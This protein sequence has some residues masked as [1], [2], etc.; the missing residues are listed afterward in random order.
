[1]N[2]VQKFV[3]QNIYCGPSLDR[4][5]SFNLV[6]VTKPNY[7]AAKTV[8]VYNINK[9]LPNRNNKFHVFAIGNLH[10][11]L[12]NLLSQEKN[13]FKDTWIK[14]SED[15][16][17][18]NYILK[19]YN[20]DGVIYPR[21][22]IY[23]TFIDESSILVAME[24]NY[25]LSQTFDVESFK[26][27]HV[28]SNAYFNS[29]EFNSLP[30][31]L[32]IQY[33]YSQVLNNIDKVNL[34]NLISTYEANGGKTFVYVNGYYTDN[35]NLNI[36]D[37]SYV[38]IVYDQSVLSKEVFHINQLRTFDSVKDNRLKYI[39]FRSK[40]IDK[41][42]YYDD[43]EIYVSNQGALVTSGLYF[44]VHRDYVAR[45][46]TDKDYSVDSTY[47]N[48][49]AST[50]SAKVGGSVNDKVIV[51][52]T[53]KPSSDKYLVYN[54]TK[55]NEL[56]KLPDDVEFDVISNTAYTI[57]ELRAEQ[58]E[59]SNYFQVA[60]LRRINQLTKELASETLGYNG[61]TYYFGYTPYRTSVANENVNVPL[62]YRINSTAFEYDNTGKFIGTYTTSGPVY[63]VN[64]SNTRYVEFLYGTTPN[65]YGRLYDHN[66]SFTLTHTEYKILS[67]YFS[68]VS[69][70]TI[71]EDITDDSSKV[72]RSGNTVQ[73]NEESGK[74]VKV[75]YFNQP[76]VYD[77]QL[78]A[79]DGVFYFPI[80]INEDRGTG[81]HTYEADVP[82][83]NI[84]VYLNGNKLTYLLDF[85]IKFPYICI[86]NKKYMNYTRLQQDIHIRC[87]GFTLD[88]DDI[89][90]L[91]SVGFVNNGVL[92]RNN[93]YDITEDRVLSIYVDGKMYNRQNILL[94]E[95]DNTIRLNN[96][97]N[98]L[99]Y[100][101][102]EPF[103]PI[104]S[105]A[106]VETLPLF[107]ANVQ[108][109]EKISN[110]YDLIYP[111]PDID[112]F[113]IIEDHHY[114]FSPTVS[115]I[116]MDML[117]NNI[118]STVYM[119]FNDATILDLL[120]QS[121]YKELLEL[122][123]VKR[124]EPN[125]IVEIHPHYGNSTI[126]VNLYQY[127]FLQRVIEIITLNNPSR[128]NLSGYLAVTT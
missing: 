48:N 119:S 45:N 60:S 66:E 27:L 3:L 8:N 33:G 105:I 25:S 94:A 89:N 47:I 16:V 17:A 58:L 121:P 65:N 51:L 96:P 68:G 50:L 111:E 118:P 120:G 67:A 20:Q 6:K 36:P 88:K 117:D 13:W 72:T 23:Y 98:G 86:C 127:R 40:I 99:P 87:Y 59:N 97:L 2:E 38:E 124:I 18:R 44:Y 57:T 90:S 31:K 77:L 63:P 122:D 9:N 116:L 39:L 103:I 15:M 54:S 62:L 93:K 55:M 22:H 110:L 26:Y 101:I 32:G 14:V 11:N 4:Q 82:Y 53:R 123:P 12:L 80:T 28:Y 113:N 108:L 92:L 84:E 10:P 69:R 91:E 29:N 109:N 112:E 41:I 81:V 5:F 79:T 104:K 115:K 126:S 125:N 56:Y 52:F 49:T 106:E 19:L 34:Q 61:I 100:V 83:R 70:I 95:N 24:I 102:K 73:L 42:Q 7:P 37:G 74:K 114:L 1:M 30:V 85:F 76:L 64:N 107:E 46:I 21:E 43:N 78:E 35:V 128:I 75:V 71:W